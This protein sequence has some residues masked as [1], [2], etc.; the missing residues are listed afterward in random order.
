MVILYFS[1]FIGHGSLV[2]A[3]DDLNRLAYSLT[4][5]YIGKLGF[6][7]HCHSGNSMEELLG[8]GR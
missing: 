5:F 1:A 8:D 6:L 4:V 7:M 3:A 2:N